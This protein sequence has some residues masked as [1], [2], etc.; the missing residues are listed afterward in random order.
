MRPPRS[1]RVGGCARGRAKPPP[2]A[3]PGST[4]RRRTGAH[5][6][7]HAD[8]PVAGARQRAGARRRPRPRS[9][10]SSSTVGGAVAHGTS[11]GRGAGVLERV[12]QRLLDDPVRGEVDARRGSGAG[13]ALDAQRRRGS[14][15]ARA[16]ADQRV[17]RRQRRLRRASARRPSGRAARRAGGASR[18]SAARP[19]RSIRSAASS[20][21]AGSRS[22]IAPR[23]AGLDDHHAHRV[24][25]DVVHLAR[26]PAPLLGTARAGLGLARLLGA[27]RALVQ[28]LGQPRAG[29]HGAAGEPA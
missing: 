12:G 1:R 18:A 15:A 27:Q 7:A 6:L 3:G 19:V 16:R 17:E 4:A 11:V 9:A 8:E 2:V 26:D 25:D 5:A 29:A 23:A 10:I 22:R 21:R 13:V 20:A 28:R 14:P 24:G